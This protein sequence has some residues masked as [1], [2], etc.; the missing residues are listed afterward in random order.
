MYT[1]KKL[2]LGEHVT[3]IGTKWTGSG[4]AVVNRKGHIVVDPNLLMGR[5][6]VHVYDCKATAEKTAA[7]FNEKRG[8]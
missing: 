2:Y 1:V 7:Y 5:W 4:F 3:D 8:N 6:N